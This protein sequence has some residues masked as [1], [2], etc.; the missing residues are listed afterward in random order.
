MSPEEVF[1]GKVV[2]IFAEEPASGGM[3]ENVRVENLNGRD[4][5]VGTLAPH[6]SRSDLRVGLPFWIAVDAIQMFAIFPDLDAA[7][8]FYDNKLVERQKQAEQQRHRWW[9]R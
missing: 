5:I 1:T 9:R 3:F 4:F 6:P 7:T 8:R 2:Q